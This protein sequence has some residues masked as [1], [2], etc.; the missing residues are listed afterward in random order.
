MKVSFFY[1]K[2]III[3]IALLFFSHSSSSEEF[4]SLDQIYPNYKGDHRFR[5]TCSPVV[6]RSGNIYLADEFSNFIY[7]YNEDLNLIDSIKI[8]SPSHSVQ[9]SYRPYS[10]A[11]DTLGQ[12]YALTHSGIFVF[13]EDLSFLHN[14]KTSCRPESEVLLLLCALTTTIVCA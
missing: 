11:V 1:I 7:K 6:D 5:N 3:L 8:P 13:D 4:Y 2:K 14:F 9:Q 10:Q 12:L